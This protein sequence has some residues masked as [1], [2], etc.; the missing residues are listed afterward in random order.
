MDVNSDTLR[1]VI[2]AI[3]FALSLAA[4]CVVILG[5]GSWW[6]FWPILLSAAFTVP[7]IGRHLK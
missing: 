5:G 2:S 7:I 1:I 3:C 4:G 6:A